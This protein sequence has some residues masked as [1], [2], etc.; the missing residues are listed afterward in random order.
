MPPKK[1]PT[2]DSLYGN[3][4]PRGS[5]APGAARSSG[6]LLT[7]VKS[8]ASSTIATLGNTATRRVGSNGRQ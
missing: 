8:A 4:H 6:V 5:R 2:A 3:I 7:N 1:L